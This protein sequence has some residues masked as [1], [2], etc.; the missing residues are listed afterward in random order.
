MRSTERVQQQNSSAHFSPCTLSIVPPKLLPAAHPGGQHHRCTVT[1]G[2]V[3]R[4]L[5][6]SFAS[7]IS[8][9]PSP[10]FPRL[11]LLHCARC[12]SSSIRPRILSRFLFYPDHVSN[13]FSL[14]Y[15]NGP[16]LCAIKELHILV[17]DRS[18]TF[19]MPS[20]IIM[21]SMMKEHSICESCEKE[22]TQKNKT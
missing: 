17:R 8:R 13:V 15:A 3:C 12:P 9:S 14:C 4:A 11:L 1:S 2:T 7:L 16:H 5:P 22:H 18:R 6:S 21:S 20:V 10:S 19:G